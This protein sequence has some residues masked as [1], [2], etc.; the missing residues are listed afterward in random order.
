MGVFKEIKGFVFGQCTDCDPSGGYG[1]LTLDQI[2]D[3][4]LLPHIIP[5][6]RGAMIGHVPRQFILPFGA[7]VPLNAD[8]GT[9]T[10]TEAIF[11]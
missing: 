11:Q 1:N 7:R 8:L 2:F 4:Y 6:Y 5:A 3:D 9:L 10:T